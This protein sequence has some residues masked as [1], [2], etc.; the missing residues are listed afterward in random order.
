MTSDIMMAWI[1]VVWNR[2]PRS[3]LSKHRML[4]LDA[5]EGPITQEVKEEIREVKSD[6]VKLGGM[7]SERGHQQDFQRPSLAAVQ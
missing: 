3:L 5:F 2:T 4:V 6:L 7:I 1:M